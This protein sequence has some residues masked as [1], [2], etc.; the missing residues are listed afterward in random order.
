MLNFNAI[1][2]LKQQKCPEKDQEKCSDK[3]MLETMRKLDK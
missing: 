1:G 3:H 2:I